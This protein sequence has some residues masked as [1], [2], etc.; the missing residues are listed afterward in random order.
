MIYWR[1]VLVIT[2]QQFV[3]SEFFLD[4]SIYLKKTGSVTFL[5]LRITERDMIINVHWSLY[6]PEVLVILVRF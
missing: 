1:P 3:L 5:T 6:R 2:V 4:I